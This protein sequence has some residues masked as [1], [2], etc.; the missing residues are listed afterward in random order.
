MRFTKKER[1]Y[2]EGGIQIT[3]DSEHHNFLN[4]LFTCSVPPLETGLKI[5]RNKE[6]EDVVLFGS[7]KIFLERLNKLDN[8][9][10]KKRTRTPKG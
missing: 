2:I 9:I 10:N 3:R 7:I 8:E 4:D 1:R 6:Q 5:S